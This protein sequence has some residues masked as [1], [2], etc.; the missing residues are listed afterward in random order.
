MDYWIQYHDAGSS[1]W[2]NLTSKRTWIDGNGDGQEDIQI[3]V[4]RSRAYRLVADFNG[5]G[6][7]DATTEDGHAIYVK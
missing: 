1:T 6:Y 3:R 2:R 4:T 7:P 5:N